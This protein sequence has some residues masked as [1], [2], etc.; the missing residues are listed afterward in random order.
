MVLNAGHLWRVDWGSI[1]AGLIS[2]H[3]LKNSISRLPPNFDTP[4]MV[5]ALK[6]NETFSEYGA[7]A[8]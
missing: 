1:A 4:L 2:P 8:A 5:S 6:N 7:I 3:G